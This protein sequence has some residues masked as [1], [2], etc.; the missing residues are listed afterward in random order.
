MLE[1]LIPYNGIE[2]VTGAKATGYHDGVLSVECADGGKDIVC[3][4]FYIVLDIRTLFNFI[5]SHLLI[6]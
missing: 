6:P 3:D 1:E 5:S 4:S 2:V